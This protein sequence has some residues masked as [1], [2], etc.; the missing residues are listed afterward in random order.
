ML[1]P[2]EC[3]NQHNSNNTCYTMGPIALT[4]MT[5]FLQSKC[6]RI[7]CTESQGQGDPDSNK[8]LSNPKGSP[9][10]I[11]TRA[12][13]TPTPKH[14]GATPKALQMLARLQLYNKAHLEHAKFHKGQGNPDPRAQWG[15][16]NS[17][18]VHSIQQL[19]MR[20]LRVLWRYKPAP[21]PCGFVPIGGEL[22]HESWLIVRVAAKP[23]IQNQL[24]K[25][26]WS[27]SPTTEVCISNM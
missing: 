8:Q 14:N 13:A 9:H 7:Q 21:A 22:C 16:P 25:Y 20:R 3:G 6:M 23:M 17:P 10:A 24:F 4:S 27:L 5:C 15:N 11:H 12:R 2:P 19:N 18:V 26:D 1:T